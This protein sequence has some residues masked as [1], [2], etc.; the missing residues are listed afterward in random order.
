MKCVETSSHSTDYIY[1]NKDFGINTKNGEMKQRL[2]FPLDLGDSRSNTKNI[3][4]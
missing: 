1:T 3:V 4:T 2:K